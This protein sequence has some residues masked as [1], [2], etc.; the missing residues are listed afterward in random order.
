[1]VAIDQRGYGDSDKPSSV[2]SYDVDN[3][4]ED[5]R[6]LID[7]LGAYVNQLICV[8]VVGVYVCV[9]VCAR[10]RV[11]VRVCLCVCARARERERKRERE[12]ER[13]GERGEREK[14]RERELHCFSPNFTTAN[15]CH[16]FKRKPIWTESGFL[17]ASNQFQILLDYLY[18]YSFPRKQL[19]FFQVYIAARE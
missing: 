13:E 11:Y 15:L 16:Y 6:Q 3:L 9:C 17:R 18:N 5:I 4:I 8:V 10:A 19:F 7:A 2:S 14:E 12:R 1:M